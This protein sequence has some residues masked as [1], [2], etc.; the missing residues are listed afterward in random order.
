MK[1]LVLLLAMLGIAG[2]LGFDIAHAAR[3]VESSSSTYTVT[4]VAGMTLKRE[5]TKSIS[6]DVVGFACAGTPG[7]LDDTCYVLTRNR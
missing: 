3:T 4:T 6:G 2:Y 1:R 7:H 5:V